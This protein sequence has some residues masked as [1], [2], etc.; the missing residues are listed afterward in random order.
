MYGRDPAG[1][2][3]TSAMY[4]PADTITA[5]SAT[6]RCAIRRPSVVGA[7]TRYARPSAGSV[8]NPCSIL[9][10]N[11]NPTA[12]P[13]SASHRGLATSMARTVA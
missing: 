1:H 11:A 4:H 5:P 7:A 3:A 10:R 9:V 12:E 6:A 2:T 8:R 13:A